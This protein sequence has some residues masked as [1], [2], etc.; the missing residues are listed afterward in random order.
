[1]QRC[2]VVDAAFLVDVGAS[3]QQ[4]LQASHH[5]GFV[6][7]ATAAAALVG[8]RNQGGYTVDIA[9]THVGT[10]GKQQLHH[11]DVAT[12]SGALQWRRA[13]GHH[14]IVAGTVV[15]NFTWQRRQLE[16]VVRVSAFFQ[17]QLCYIKTSG[18]LYRRQIATL[19]ERYDIGVDSRIQWRAAPV[20]P[21]VDISA[22]LYQVFG[23]IEAHV[24]QSENQR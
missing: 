7:A 9:K 10:A 3:L 19:A 13:S 12:V 6:L 21:L 23:N 2:F 8:H 20:V 5:L 24:D 18:Q 16:V 4:H 15:S 11:V 17:Q 14:W 22:L 1:M